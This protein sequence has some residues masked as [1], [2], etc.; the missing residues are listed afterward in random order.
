MTARDNGRVVQGYLAEVVNERR[1]DRM[2]A[3]LSDDFVIDHPGAGPVNT[4][5]G[6]TGLLGELVTAFPDLTVSI[7]EVVCEGDAV[8]V[9]LGWA[10][11]HQGTFHG[12]QPS[13]RR[14][15]VT[16]SAVYHV[17]DG[18]ISRAWVELDRLG[19]LQQIRASPEASV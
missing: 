4:A 14:F 17:I 6:L 3:F 1:F 7:D 15:A 19:L 2:P 5:A 16:G 9:R 13:G 11:S 10:G 8:A 12:Q 18:R